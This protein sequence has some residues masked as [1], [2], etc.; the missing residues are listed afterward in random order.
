MEA[1]MKSMLRKVSALVLATGAVAGGAPLAQAESYS[2]WAP[3]ISSTPIVER[4][5]QAPR[6][7]C[8]TE[9]VTNYESRRIG[10]ISLGSFDTSTN[11]VVPVSRDVQRCRT[12]DQSTEVV[13][14]YEVR[15]RYQGREY[16]TR[17]ATD[18]GSRIRVDVS[19]LPGAQ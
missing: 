4:V 5:A 11:V 19:V 16:V 13:Q 2:E 8:W 18:P 10:G 7:D 9:R 12:I 6:E 15:Y 1:L 3:V 14:G 17:T